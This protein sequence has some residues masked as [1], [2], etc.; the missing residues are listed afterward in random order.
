MV[1]PILN[2][3]GIASKNP[4]QLAKLFTLLQLNETH[5]ERVA[6]QNVDTTFFPLPETT[7]HLEVLV[8]IDGKGVIQDYLDKRGGGVHHLSFELPKG[9]LDKLSIVLK[10]EGF[11]LVYPEPRFGAS[12]MRV[13]FIHPKSTGGV[14]VELTEPR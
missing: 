3:I 9:E 13:Q 12:E 6:E 7:T 11:E 4:K 1:R 14:L 8:P 2:H 10:R 5:S